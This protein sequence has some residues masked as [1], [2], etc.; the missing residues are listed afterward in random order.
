MQVLGDLLDQMSLD[1]Q[2]HSVYTDGAYDT[3]QCLQLIPDR[4]AN[5][6]IPLRKNAKPWKD[7]KVHSQERNE[8]LRTIKSF[9]RT[10]W[11]SSARFVRNQDALHQ[12]NRL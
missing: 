7:I 4:Q 2:I 1:E 9:G 3:K 5:A 6:V 11:L 10:L 8:L 12:I